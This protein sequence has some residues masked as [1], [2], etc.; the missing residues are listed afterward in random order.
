MK[1]KFSLLILLLSLSVLSAG[2]VQQ[3]FTFSEP[4]IE[5]TDGY[6][7]LTIKDLNSITKPGEP[8]LPSLPVQMLLPAGEK[9]VEIEVT[10]SQRELLPGNFNLYPSQRQ[11]PL[12]YDGD[13]KFEQPDPD[14]YQGDGL[15]P[16][17]LTTKFTTQYLRGHSIAL[18][19]LYPVQYN[20]Q[21]GEI[22]FYRDLRVNVHTAPATEAQNAF[23]NYY[24]ADMDTQTRISYLVSN[25]E[26]LSRYPVSGRHRDINDYEY[27]IISPTQFLAELNDFVTFKQSQ[28]YHVF[29][30]TTED[31]YAEYP[32]TDIADQIRNFIKDAYQTMGAEFVLLVGDTSLLPHRGFW[33]DASGT[34]D[35]GI[36]SELYYEGLD[37][38][39]TGTGPDWNIDSDIRWGE[40]DEAD[41]FTEVHVGRLSVENTTELAA[42][43]NKQMMYQDQPVVNQLEN[44][45]TVGEQLNDNPVTWGGN[46][47]DEIITGGTFNGY[48]TVGMPANLN[49]QTLYER[50]GYWS[51]SQLAS[52][53]NSG[54][55]FL[56]HLGHSNVDYNMKF[57][58]STVTNQSITANGIDTNFFLIYSQG[59]LPAAIEQDC[60][61]EKFT[62]IENGCVAFVGNSRYGWYS[63]GGTNSSSQYMDRQFFNALFDSDITKLSSLNAAS[64]EIG[65]SQ[66]YQSPWFRWS[67][68]CLIVLGDPTLDIWTAEPVDINAVYQ[69]SV[70]MGTSQVLF[71]TDTPFARIALLQNDQ[72]LGR[73]VTDENGDA[74]L[75]TFEPIL[76]P[77]EITVSIIGH[78]KNRHL[79]TIVVISN[80]PYIVF[81][82]YEINDTAGNNNSEPDFGESI[83]L[84]MTL[85]NLG[86]QPSTGVSAIISTD[87]DYVTITDDSANFGD[88]APQQL[89]TV[90]D[91]FSMDIAELIP[92]QHLVQFTLEVTG[93]A[94]EIWTST[95]QLIL[96]APEIAADNMFVND[97]SGN[98]NGI[99][100]PGETATIIINVENIG[101]ALSPDAMAGIVSNN[102][103]VTFDNSVANLG[104]INAQGSANATYGVTAD[105]ALEIGTLVEFNL[106]VFAGQYTMEKTFTHQ[107]GLI[108]EN[109]ET[110]DFSA[111][112]WEFTGH[113]DWTISD[114][115]Y[116]GSFCAMSG[117]IDHNQN[118]GLSLEIDVVSPGE[119]SFYRTVSSEENYDYLKFFVD[120]T[121]MAE[122]SGEVAWD[123]ETYQLEAGNHLLEWKYVKDQG[124]ASGTDCARIDYIIFPP[125]GVIF[126]PMININPN[127][128]S[129][130]MPA[131]STQ[132]EILGISNIG[133]EVLNYSISTVNS[134]D[135][136]SYNPESGSLNGG[137]MDEITLFFDSTD[138]PGGTYY[139][140]LLVDDGLGEQ[141]L[142]PVTLIVTA[143][144]NNNDLIPIKTELFGNHPNP[145]NP[146]TEIKYGLN[147]DSQV[148]LNIYNVKG[149]KVKT[150]VNEVQNAGYHSAVWN[151]LDD[152]NKQVTSGIYFYEFRVQGTDYT[153]I[154]KM[155]LLK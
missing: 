28:G 18:F 65:A 146:V 106:V 152:A 137:Q 129:I 6:H 46:Y 9:A 118:S 12:N 52:Y 36:P 96:N 144:G 63:P 10:F 8:Q 47:K 19:N 88:F 80:Q 42:A 79:G 149:Q 13:I 3:T 40:T 20:P 22:I 150:L 57:Y 25:Q 78:N 99:L 39:G 116:E 128:V 147:V 91:A 43:L 97:S 76:S 112:P 71:Q 124:V 92:D 110:A 69:P 143:T 117:Q 60:I 21:T 104:Q 151:G 67:Y 134:P 56:N 153:S 127:L 37:R 48:T 7:K 84:N 4:V 120:G 111:F 31:I 101:H 108:A 35:F 142:V 34:T 94:D 24:R 55:N 83:S 58:N 121:L 136:L 130:E 17:N 98:N 23:N 66:C 15:F 125:L 45:L 119:L 148:S 109:F 2:I 114:G 68:Y 131:N 154:K 53:M 89:V 38:V 1:L 27:I 41:F 61:A 82:S 138:L 105:A 30:K 85:S 16:D 103:L 95:F 59:C 62:T 44:V 49:V 72:L 122:W 70:L 113:A 135:W 29:T 90:N 123:Q 93:S 73:A 155:I 32:G 139:S 133:G 77:E 100:D 33:V 5:E 51:A 87:D 74:V 26:E 86:N 141:H 132:N 107:I 102:P 140:G 81:D 11:Y 145:F 64:K 75:E 54:L 50:D 14:I 115:A 126:P